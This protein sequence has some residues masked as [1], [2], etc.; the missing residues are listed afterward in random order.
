MTNGTDGVSRSSYSGDASE[1]PASI[2]VIGV[3]GGGCNA[4][5][6]IMRERT[7]PGVKY[8]C[9]NTDVKSLNSV[10]GATIVQIG[11]QMTRGMGAGGNPEVG[12]DAAEKDR[13]NLHRAIGH[14]DLIFLTAGMGGG[15]GTGAAP[16]VAAIAKQTGAL[17]VGLVTTPFSWEGSRRLASA[18]AGVDRLQAAVDSLIVVHN[19]RLLQLLN[20]DVSMEEALRRAD[21]AVM[22]GV[23][24][25]A[26]LVNVPGEINVD[27]ADV[28]TILAL[29]GRALMAMGEAPEPNGAPAAAKIAIAN[30]LLNLSVDGAQGVLFCVNGGP[31]LT[32]GEVNEAGELIASKVSSKAIVFFGMVNDEKMQD[33]VRVTM[34]AT[35]I[36]DT[37]NGHSSERN[38][39]E[40]Q[41]GSAAHRATPSGVGTKANP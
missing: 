8:V 40:G 23:L 24:S 21:E 22:Y 19:D 32:L 36:P 29:Q 9:V 18:M 27:L 7:V 30:P 13:V 31:K 35:G 14:P 39:W 3:G 4:V 26:E 2:A 11:E 33:R 12:R 20:K 38:L 16:V 6:R 25:V 37:T 28:K 10:K 15:T 1:G 41:A 17:V 34:I 5:M